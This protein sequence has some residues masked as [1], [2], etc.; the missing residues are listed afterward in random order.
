MWC[1]VGPVQELHKPRRHGHIE[2]YP[3]VKLKWTVRRSKRSYL[4]AAYSKGAFIRL[5]H[6]SAQNS[7]VQYLN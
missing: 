6:S 4:V 3:S 2:K 1:H 7:H 5:G